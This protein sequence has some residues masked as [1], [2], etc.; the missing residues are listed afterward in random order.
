MTSIALVLGSGGARGYA[1]LGVVEVL[2]ER[3]LE[4]AVI[5]GTSM[6]ALV[7]GLTAAGKEQEFAEWARRLT[8]R[9]IWRML[10]PTTSGG[11]IF[12]IEK[13]IGK[14]SE[15]LDG[16]HIEDL[17]VPYTAVATDVTSQREVW[18]Q[19]GPLDTAIRAS[20]AI[21]T[22]VTPV[23]LDGHLIVDGALLNPVP[24][25]PT[26]S[27]RTDLTVAVDLH[28]RPAGQV[29]RGPEQVSS[30]RLGGGLV[31]TLSDLIGGLRWGSGTEVTVSDGAGGAGGVVP[32]DPAGPQP[33]AAHPPAPD[34]PP[35]RVG[36]TLPALTPAPKDV[37][38]LD[39]MNAS[40]DTMTGLVTRYRLASNPP[41]VTVRVPTDACTTMDYHRAA[42]MIALGRALAEE[43]LAAHGL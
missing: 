26:M 25:D 32:G 13:V 14:V 16:V 39:L 5:A 15:I 34:A 40:L 38:I 22:V 33:D 24:I 17:P 30:E 27:V 18:F 21:P 41:D 9:D 36:G 12:R 29:A 8:Q 3:G 7:G 42:E 4:I 1:H 19:H 28:G 2:R 10:G 6:G 37:R 20:V 31:R 35:A 43:A 11:G 23:M